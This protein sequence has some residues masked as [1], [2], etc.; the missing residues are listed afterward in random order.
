MRAGN[1]GDLLKGVGGRNLLVPVQQL[2]KLPGI[3]RRLG[4]QIVLRHIPS[5]QAWLRGGL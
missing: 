2:W 4:V 3:C 1:D 5:C